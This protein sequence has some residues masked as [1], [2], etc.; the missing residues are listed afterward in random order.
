MTPDSVDNMYY[1]NLK[2]VG[3]GQCAVGHTRTETKEM[4]KS[5]ANHPSV[6]A[7]K[8]AAAMVP[9]GSIEVLTGNQ[10]EIRR[11][12]WAVNSRVLRT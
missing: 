8:F 1:K 12:C 6:W 4:V 10:G 3:K 2:G 9:V 5:N 11:N 7:Q